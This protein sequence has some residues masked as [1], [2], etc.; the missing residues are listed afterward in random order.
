MTIEQEVEAFLEHFGTRGMKWGVRNDRT[1]SSGQVKKGSADVKL[2]KGAKV[3]NVSINK[4]RANKGH[5][6]TAHTKRDVLNYRG[7]YA[8]QLVMFNGADK[9]FSNAFTVKSGI[10]AAGRETQ[11][12][13]FKKLWETDKDGVARALAESQK[14]MKFSAA[15]NARI[16]KLDRE[17]VYHKRIMNKGE[18]WVQNKGVEEFS[19]SMGAGNKSGK[20]IYFKEMEKRGYNA[21]V[22]LNDVRVYGSDQPL[23]IFN[24][25]KS[26]KKHSSIQLT[27]KD[28]RK[29]QEA[30]ASEKLLSEYRD[31]LHND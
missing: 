14:D 13:A 2:A 17:N 4:E 28:V 3:L 8:Q 22:D 21:I 15:F 6:Y 23:L 19:A 24:G 20:A 5:I 10:N 9:V 27:E 25:S 7:D 31:T 16:L 18:K 30:Y 1:G 29:A 11:V 12:K 26:L